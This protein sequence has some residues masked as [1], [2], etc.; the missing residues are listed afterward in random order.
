MEDSTQ[1]QTHD[2]H[3]GSAVSRSSS[4]AST[5]SLD[6]GCVSQP[7]SVSLKASFLDVSQH[8]L[9][10]C[11]VRPAVLPLVSGEHVGFQ[12]SKLTVLPLN[13]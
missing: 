9:S 10:S 3:S 1:V 7:G 11:G 6:S 12:G 5:L 8:S 13:A 2:F 4:P